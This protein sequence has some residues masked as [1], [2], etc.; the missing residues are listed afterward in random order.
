MPASYLHTTRAPIHMQRAQ[1]AGA[2]TFLAATRD[3]AG[4]RGIAGEGTNTVYQLH[5]SNGGEG[6]GDGGGCL[7]I[8]GGQP[9]VGAYTRPLLSSK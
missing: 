9:S 8:K 4:A 6:G 1:S 2:A 3:A 5:E 7:P